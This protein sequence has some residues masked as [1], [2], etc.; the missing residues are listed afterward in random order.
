MFFLQVIYYNRKENIVSLH[1]WCKFGSKTWNVPHNEVWVWVCQI[2]VWLHLKLATWLN[3]TEKEFAEVSSYAIAENVTNE[4]LTGWA[5]FSVCAVFGHH[6]PV[7]EGWHAWSP[8]PYFMC[9]IWN[10]QMQRWGNSE[11]EPLPLMCPLHVFGPMSECQKT[12]SAVLLSVCSPKYILQNR[13]GRILPIQCNPS[14]C[15]TELKTFIFSSPVTV[16]ILPFLLF[17]LKR[18]NIYVT[19]SRSIL[20]LI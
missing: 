11:K 15:C 13:D 12:Y 16:C 20:L 4:W 8:N 6:S 1:A 2:C 17:I 9:Y 7:W 3:M 10:V 14:M 5:L 19:S 18:W